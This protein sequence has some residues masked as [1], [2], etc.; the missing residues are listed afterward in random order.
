MNGAPRRASSSSTG[1]W[2]RSTSS[3]TS[4]DVEPRDRRER[5]HAAGVRAGVAVADALVVAGRREREGAPPVAEREHRQLLALEQLLDD[6]AAPLERAAREAGVELRLRP[7]DEHALAGG[8]PVGLD[9]AGGAGIGERR[10]RSGRPPPPALP[11]RSSSIPRC[12]RRRHS[13][14]RRESPRDGVGR[15][16]RDQRRLGPDDSEIDPSAVASSSS[17]SPSSAG[18]GWQVAGAAIPG[19]PGAACSS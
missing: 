1:A 18:T 13:G 6:D 14:R 8:E 5:A 11:W 2:I 10:A 7:A 3:S 12:A 4:V 16:P 17:P 9:H 15:R 19:F